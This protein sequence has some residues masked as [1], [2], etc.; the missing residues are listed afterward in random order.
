MDADTKNHLQELKQNIDALYE[1]GQLHEAL[2]AANIYFEKCKELPESDP[3]YS[4]LLAGALESRADMLRLGDANEQACEDYILAIEKLG[5]REN[6][7][8]QLGRLHAGLGAAYAALGESEIAARQWELSMECFEKNVPPS[9]LDVAAMA[10]N[11]GFLKKS[12]GDYDSAENAFLKALEILHAELG[13]RHEETA[14]VAAN[15]GELYMEAG[16]HGPA[17]KMYRIAV[18]AR[19]AVLGDFHPDTAQSRVHL[20][21]VHLNTGDRT[22]ARRLFEKAVQAYQSLGRDFHSEFIKVAKKYCELLREDG[23]LPMAEAITK[24]VREVTGELAFA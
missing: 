8:I 14:T 10:N 13:E 19:A 20:A 21:T 1:S 16:H 22:G 15:L 18:N 9:P 23:E 11:F 3:E 24:H 6:N 12:A 7:L 4:E 17:A 2:Q 5:K